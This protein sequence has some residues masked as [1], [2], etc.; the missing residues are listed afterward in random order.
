MMV[1]HIALYLFIPLSVILIKVTAI[2]NSFNF[3]KKKKM[4][5]S[6]KVQTL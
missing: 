2:S 5:L 6:S 1:L 3:K 4:F